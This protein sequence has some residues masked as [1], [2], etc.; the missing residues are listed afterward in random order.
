MVLRGRAVL[1]AVPLRGSP[2]WSAP[3]D[4]GRVALD[5]GDELVDVG[6]R[7]VVFVGVEVLFCGRASTAST[8]WWSWCSAVGRSGSGSS[9]RTCPKVNNRKNV[10]SVEGARLPVNNLPIPPW[11]SMSI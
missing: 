1:T 11:R 2:V 3:E 9:W 6:G 7:W 10:T 4:T 8:R 5:L